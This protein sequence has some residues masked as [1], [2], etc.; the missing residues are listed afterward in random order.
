[1]YITNIS[2]I[3]IVNSNLYTNVSEVY[4]GRI[5]RLIVKFSFKSLNII[6]IPGK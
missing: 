4:V 2:I 5:L 3:D 1:M 6:I